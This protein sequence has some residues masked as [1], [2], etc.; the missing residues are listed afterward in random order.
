MKIPSAQR[1][2]AVAS[3]Q[4]MTFWDKPMGMITNSKGQSVPPNYAVDITNLLINDNGFF[5]PR[6]GLKRVTTHPAG[7]TIAFPDVFSAIKTD[8]YCPVG[9][10]YYRLIVDAD[11]KLYK[12][13]GTEPNL[14]PGAA[15]AA[16]A[17]PAM[18]LPFS[19]FAVIL[20]GSYIKYFDGTSVKLA[21][22]D[23]SDDKASQHDTTCQA[24]D[25]ASETKV[26][27]GAI[28]M[29]GAA[30]TTQAWDAGYT[31]DLTRVSFWIKKTGSPT[32]TIQVKIYSDDTGP[33]TL[34]ATSTT[35][36][37]ASV[38]TGNFYQQEFV[39]A[40]GALGLS[41]ETKYYAVIDYSDGSAS[42]Y[43]T[44]AGSA[45]LAGSGDSWAFIA[46]WAA[47]TAKN[48]LC[49][50]APG[51]PPKAKFG[52]AK[53]TRLFVAG[54]P[55]NPG[56][57]Y[58]GNVNSLFDWSTFGSAGYVS[59]VDDNASSFPIGAIVAHYG[60]LYVWGKKEQP[61]LCKLTGSG[62]DDF[63]LPPLWQKT[64][65]EHHN[66]LSLPNNVWIASP[67]GLNSLGGVAE[68]GDL[69]VAPYSEAVEDIFRAYWSEAA[70]IG[71]HPD[72]EQIMIKLSGY[73]KT[74]VCHTRQPKSP[75]CF[76]N[77]KDITPTCFSNFNGATY[78]GAADGH[79]Y[80]LDRTLVK[81]NSAAFDIV[82][83]SGW[84][85]QPFGEAMLDN[86]YANVS[87][88]ISS[89]KMEIFVD[90]ITATP[91]YTKTITNDVRPMQ[92]NVHTLGHS[93]K[94]KLSEF[95][96]TGRGT[97]HSLIFMRRR[98]SRKMNL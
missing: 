37:D 62:P 18:I 64:Y 46:A 68:Y 96:L 15:I 51:K 54:N 12:C 5:Q 69:R 17:G 19:G 83:E 73:S 67:D 9:S 32:G 95:V 78:V 36:V 39:F 63:S 53:D 3:L 13:T 93:I 71:Y 48:I 23:G 80:K 90:G 60:D 74:L 76:Y 34:L 38:L 45:A 79:I 31:I 35:E 4:P 28:T 16:L 14:D 61:Y 25:D 2:Q 1:S 10:S 65:T 81:D 7:Y 52:D 70:F 59:A 43:I 86:M 50:V 8:V 75:W 89:Y 84:I 56:L 6:P 77:F 85:E 44:L 30:F 97:I 24:F 55:D 20:D 49:K 22:D 47:D 33:D 29:A 40:E 72:N 57:L 27:S 98:L 66:L 58:Y 11:H 94:I 26:Y 82:L 88:E 41:P 92:R 21:Y 87:S 42:K 91:K